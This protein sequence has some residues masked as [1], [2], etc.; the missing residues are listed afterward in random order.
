MKAK[1]MIEQEI[2]FRYVGI[3]VPVRYEEEDIPNDFPMRVGDMWY[4]L[5]DIDTAQIHDWPIGKSGN[6]F[7]K[8][9]DCGSYTLFDEKQNIVGEIFDDYCPNALIPGEYGDYINLKIDENG[10]ITNWLSNPDVS[11]FFITDD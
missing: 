4:A 9:T 6:M 10:I 5:V 11:E 8:V 3:N 7:M 2:D 1:V